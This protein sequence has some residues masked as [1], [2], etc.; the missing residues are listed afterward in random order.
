[1][2]RFVGRVTCRLAMK[3]KSNYEIRAQTNPFPP[4]KQQSIVVA[5]D[6]GEHRKHEQVQ[7]SKKPVVSAFVRHVADGV[8]VNQHPNAGDEQQPDAGKGIEQESGVRLESS[9]LAV[10][11]D[12]VQMPRVRAQPRI[13]DLLI[14]FVVMMGRPIRVLPD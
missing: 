7:V 14:R 13:N 12:V 4:Y 11:G 10:V 2:E 9:Q 3:V 6:E 8:D 5:E 1:D